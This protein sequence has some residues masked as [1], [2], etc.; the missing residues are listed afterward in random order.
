[1]CTLSPIVL[2]RELWSDFA[3]SD[4]DANVFSFIQEMPYISTSNVRQLETEAKM[5]ESKF[6]KNVWARCLHWEEE[7]LKSTM[8]FR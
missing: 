1:M 8:G 5:T 6:S 7:A 4:T 2:H 3:L